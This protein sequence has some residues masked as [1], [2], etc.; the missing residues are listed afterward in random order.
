MICGVFDHQHRCWWGRE[1]GCQPFAL[2]RCTT[3]CL[4]SFLSTYV[5]VVS[6]ENKG[7][8]LWDGM[9]LAGVRVRLM[10]LTL[11]DV[12]QTDAAI[13]PGNSGGPLL[14]SD[15]NLIGESAHNFP[16][17]SFSCAHSAVAAACAMAAPHTLLLHA[18]EHHTA[19]LMLL[20][21]IICAWK[22]M[23]SGSFHMTCQDFH[24]WVHLSLHCPAATTMPTEHI[25]PIDYRASVCLIPV[26]WYEGHEADEGFLL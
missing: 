9:L 20:E 23:T 13:N 2:A 10:S 26:R 15:G 6:W 12:I 21:S 3:D 25:N 24:A 14:D 4:A 18:Q 8:F 11:Q 19:P 22:C 1:L 5:V 16:T 7:Q 17:S